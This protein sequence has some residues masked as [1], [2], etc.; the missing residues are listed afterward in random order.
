MKNFLVI[1]LVLAA[2]VPAFASPTRCEVTGNS[3]QKFVFTKGEKNVFVNLVRDE[4]TQTK[5]IAYTQSKSLLLLT[6][7]SSSFQLVS[8]NRGP[9]SLETVFEDRSNLESI[10]YSI[11]GKLDDKVTVNEAM[12]LAKSAA[13]SLPICN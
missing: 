3:H 6:Q 9:L 5:S 7:S 2:S 13:N 1:A 12:A 10:L 8:P 11:I 4:V